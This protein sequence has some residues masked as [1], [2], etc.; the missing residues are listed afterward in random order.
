MR[1]EF[2]KEACEGWF[3]CTQEWSAFTMN[4]QAGKAELEGAT[5]SED[6]VVVREVPEDEVEAAISAAEACPIDVIRVYDG[7][8][9]IVP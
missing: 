3:Q 8:E 1:V 6:G 9:Q 4:V 7:D 2:D 5:E